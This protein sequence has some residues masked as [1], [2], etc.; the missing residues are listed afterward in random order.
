MEFSSPQANNLFDYSIWMFLQWYY[1][2]MTL[3]SKGDEM[4]KFISHF[5]LNGVKPFTMCPTK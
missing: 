2:P 5:T 3:I 4:D 1:M